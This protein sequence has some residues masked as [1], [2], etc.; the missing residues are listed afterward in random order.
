MQKTKEDDPI[1]IHFVAPINASINLINL[2]KELK[3]AKIANHCPNLSFKKIALYF[4]LATISIGPSCWDTGTDINQGQLYLNGDN[5]TKY[6]NDT[7][8]FSVTNFTCTLIETTKKIVGDIEEVTYTYNCFEKDEFFGYLTLTFVFLVPGI[9]Q[10][11]KIFI[12]SGSLEAKSHKIIGY[13]IGIGLFFLSPLF[14]LQIFLVK[15]LA[16]LTDGPEMK[17]ISTL[18]TFHEATIESQFQIILQ[19]Y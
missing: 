10:A 14:P 8:D 17:K 18:M 19:I 9:F 16:F 12:A 5:Y 15:L 3:C 4:F 6:V 13:G 7:N 2:K 1:L 11:I